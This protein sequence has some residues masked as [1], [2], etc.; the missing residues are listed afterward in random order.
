MRFLT[1]VAA[2]LLAAQPVFAGGFAEEMDRLFRDPCL[3]KAD[4]CM[5]VKSIREGLVKYSKNPDRLLIP[6][7]NMKLI[8]SAAA[9]DILK[10]SYRFKT[11]F[12]H[13]GTR[14]GDTVNG[15]L[16]IKGYGNPHLVSEDLWIMVNE[17]WKR[18]IR[19]IT[20]NVVI[21][22]SFFDKQKFPDTWRFSKNR[23]AFESPSGALSLNFNSITINIYPD[24]VT[25]DGLPHA[26][27]DPQTSYFTLVNKM[28]FA[29]RGKSRLTITLSPRKGGGE[30]VTIAGD[31]VKGSREMTYYRSVTDP[32]LYFGLTF[33]SFAQKAGIK[34][35]GKVVNGI[36]GDELHGV[37]T[38][39]SRP[40][41]QLLMDMNKYSNN[42]MAEQ[43]IKT[44]GANAGSGPGGFDAG[45]S[46]VE[47][48]LQSRGFAP[49]GYRV[50]DGSG[51][52]RENRV[53]CSLIVD[54]LQKMYVQWEG[55]PEFITSL[56]LMG[57]EGSVKER[58]NHNKKSI[59]VKTGT[60]DSISSLSGYYPT[61]SG[62][63]LIF[64]MIV[65]NLSCG[66]GQLQK[67]QD[68]MLKELEKLDAGKY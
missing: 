12:F 43:I 9:L 53:S 40:L 25:N 16:I 38:H 51:L 11:E 24:V 27:L 52:S 66:N 47:A 49:D 54:L 20:G 36:S 1:T 13:T 4:A 44:I 57:M 14:N 23:R 34:V 26:V 33:L 19:R 48:F 60:L 17:L 15:D 59:R 5:I 68:K 21:D 31:V 58:D 32:Y 30:I 61:K 56:A 18:G 39:T 63:V 3:R 55:G 50:R 35:D 41:Y 65:N 2:V 10:P 8:T 67:L 29:G 62:S 42:F 6:A 37:Y 22:D 7:S 64:S 28:R 45:L 46:R